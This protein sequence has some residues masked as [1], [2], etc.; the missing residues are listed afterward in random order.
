MSC[1]LV[2]NHSNPENVDTK[3][4]SDMLEAWIVL[5]KT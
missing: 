2:H 4:T 1:Q 5:K 3:L